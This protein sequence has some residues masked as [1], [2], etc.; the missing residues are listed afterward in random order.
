M[1]IQKEVRKTTFWG[2][3][4]FCNKWVFRRHA[5]L[6]SSFVFPSHNKKIL[7]MGM[8]KYVHINLSLNFK[9]DLSMLYNISFY[10]FWYI[11]SFIYGLL[12]NNDSELSSSSLGRHD[13]KR[14]WLYCDVWLWKFTLPV[15]SLTAFSF[16]NSMI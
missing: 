7:P 6:R 15:L 12:F 13:W 11:N 16:K 5:V 8:S 1:Y 3:F 10:H 2:T 9:H 14:N 4:C